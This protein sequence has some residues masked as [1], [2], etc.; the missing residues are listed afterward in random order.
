MSV[1]T[2][3]CESETEVGGPAEGRTRRQGPGQDV[4]YPCGIGT[5]LEG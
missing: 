3:L 4:G 2:S 1:K 5:V